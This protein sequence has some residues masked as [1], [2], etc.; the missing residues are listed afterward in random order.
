[1][2]VE[3][4]MRDL[5]I[6]QLAEIQSKLVTEVEDKKEELRQMVGRRYRDVLDASNCVRK[7]AEMAKQLSECVAE[8]YEPLPS[9]AS[10]RSLKNPSL[11]NEETIYRFVMLDR[12]QQ[13]IAVTEDSLSDAFVLLLAENLHRSL[14]VEPNLPPNVVATL[15]RLSPVF[16]KQRRELLEHC[17]AKLGELSDQNGTTNVLLAMVVLNPLTPEELVDRYFNARMEKVSRCITWSSSLIE[18]L[19]AMHDTLTAVDSLFGEGKAFGS[20]L[21]VVKTEGWR[22]ERVQMVV[23]DQLGAYHRFIHTEIQKINKIYD[24]LQSSIDTNILQ[25]KCTSWV[26]EICDVING[27]MDELSRHIESTGL[28][29]DFLSMASELF[30]T[31]WPGIASKNVIYDKMFGDK[32]VKR[33]VVL[34]QSELSLAETHLMEGW[35]TLVWDDCESLFQKRADKFDPLLASGVSKKLNALVEKFSGELELVFDSVRRFEKLGKEFS[36]VVVADQFADMVLQLVE[37]LT[38]RPSTSTDQPLKLFRLY[39]ALIAFQPSVICA[40]MDR[41]AEKI[42]R[43]SHMLV[44]AAQGA[45]CNHLD[46]LIQ[47]CVERCNL[48]SLEKECAELFTMI[49][50]LQENEKVD[51]EQV[52]VFNIPTQ[53]NRR[54]HEFFMMF[55]NETVQQ[56]IGHLCNKSVRDHLQKAFAQIFGNLM[57]KCGEKSCSLSAVCSQLLFDSRVLYLLFPTLELKA[58]IQNLEAKMDPFD[59]SI[60]SELISQNAKVAVERNSLL[61]GMISS[62]PVFSRDSKVR[63]SYNLLIDTFP[64][65]TDVPRLSLIPRLLKYREVEGAK[66][67]GA[68]I[69]LPNSVTQPAKSSTT[70]LTSFYDKISTGWFRKE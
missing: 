55:A 28:V 49:D 15:R 6:D 65:I 39:L 26:T 44:Q 58:S 14:S 63:E 51:I 10:D 42:V 9:A 46:G 13:E 60:V 64:R 23:N 30:R 17:E 25:D 7:L 41:S 70:S 66:A 8:T 12:L 38:N 48:K 21:K 56:G 2:D 68:M 61:F 53:I 31:N 59:L 20:G 69:G 50:L 67:D 45:L 37:R 19:Q 43:C 52:G 33:F 47:L 32:L 24:S 11:L 57:A 34:I 4:L 22:P 40:S 27:Q 36:T 18:V 1:M 35:T 29:V 5:N 54:F 62:E 16:M 3:R